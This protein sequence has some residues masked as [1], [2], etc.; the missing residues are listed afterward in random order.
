MAGT[1]FEV[2]PDE[3]GNDIGREFKVAYDQLILNYRRYKDGDLDPT[4]V[5]TTTESTDVFIQIGVG[6]SIVLGLFLLFMTLFFGFLYFLKST[7]ISDI[8]VEPQQ[9]TNL[10]RKGETVHFKDVIN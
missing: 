10:L 1:R 7:S 8:P 3:R 4:V 6:I 9:E 5:D 2:A